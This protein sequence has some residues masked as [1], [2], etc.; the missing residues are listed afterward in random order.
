MNLKFL[1]L[2]L[3]EDKW[4]FFLKF[5]TWNEN[6][7][8]KI[9]QKKT[10]FQRKKKSTWLLN[11]RKCQFTF[12]IFYGVFLLDKVSLTSA[13]IH[14]SS[15]MQWIN[16]TER[17]IFVV[18]QYFIS[19]YASTESFVCLHTKEENPENIKN[20]F[21][22]RNCCSITSSGKIIIFYMLFN[23]FIVK[24]TFHIQLFFISMRCIST[25][26]LLVALDIGRFK[27]RFTKILIF[28]FHIKILKIGNR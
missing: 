3:F 14:I 7:R 2:F 10:N 27:S 28:G 21:Y 16:K 6:I 9:K 23:I 24:Y 25:I 12:E 19:F 4:I 8:R 20:F 11:E 13:H 15:H 1:I 26:L 17:V 5:K 22:H 18:G